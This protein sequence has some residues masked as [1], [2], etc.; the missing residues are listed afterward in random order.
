MSAKIPSPLQPV[1]GWVMKAK[2]HLFYTN[3]FSQSAEQHWAKHSHSRWLSLQRV[4]TC[5][6]SLSQ[7]QDSL[8]CLFGLRKHREDLDTEAELGT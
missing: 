1:S 6:C 5:S 8:L 2:D 3:V 7:I 4:L